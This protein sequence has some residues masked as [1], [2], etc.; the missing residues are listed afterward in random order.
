MDNPSRLNRYKKIIRKGINSLYPTFF[1]ENEAN[2]NILK[3][4]NHGVKSFLFI[5]HNKGITG[6]NNIV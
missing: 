6:K 5:K 1:K 3:G 4:L 2:L